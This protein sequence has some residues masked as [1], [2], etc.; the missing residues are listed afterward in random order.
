MKVIQVHKQTTSLPL[1][2]I[3]YITKSLATHK[4]IIL[5]KQDKCLVL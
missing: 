2:T 3:Q 4:Y 1:I 5:P